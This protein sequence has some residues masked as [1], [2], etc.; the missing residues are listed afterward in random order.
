MI[1][2]INRLTGGEMWVD[3]KRMEEYLSAGH[4]PVA[5]LKSA[6]TKP[7]TRKKGGRRK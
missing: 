7:S 3:E 6:G 5:D 1:K 2:F 4:V